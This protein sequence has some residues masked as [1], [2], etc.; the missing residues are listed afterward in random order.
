MKT[1]TPPFFILTGPPG[2]G[3]TTLIESLAKH[4]KVVPEAARRVLMIERASGGAATGE[5]DA[6]AF[7]ARMLDMSTADY[8]AATGLTVL[9][10]EEQPGLGCAWFV[11]SI[12]P[13][14][15]GDAAISWMPLPSIQYRQQ[16]ETT[17]GGLDGE[18]IPGLGDAARYVGSTTSGSVWVLLDELTFTVGNQFAFSNVEGR[19]YQ[20]ALAHALVDALT[21][22]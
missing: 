11:D 4:V 12:D 3:K 15:T 22:G 2:S 13:D 20:E 10:S 9:G 21:T 5:Q 19:P 17:D 7:V 1:E 8:A 14:V 6:A 16:L 18:E